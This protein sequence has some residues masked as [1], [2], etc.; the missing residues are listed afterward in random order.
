MAKTIASLPIPL[1]ALL[2]GQPMKYNSKNEEVLDK[3]PIA[4]PIGYEKPE[5]LAELVQRMVKNQAYLQ[6]FQ[7]KESYEEAN[8]FDI[9]DDGEELPYTTKFD[10]TEMKEEYLEEEKEQTTVE[11]T[12][13][14]PSEATPQTEPT[15]DKVAT[16]Q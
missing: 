10:F 6:H 2:K 8:D 5:T 13:E 12:T 11:A 15:L 4:L 3:T 16:A 9:D 14:K 7:G 1:L